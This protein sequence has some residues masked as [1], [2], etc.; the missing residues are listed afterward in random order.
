MAGL[1]HNINN[2][3][4]CKGFKY[5][6]YQSFNSGYLS[7]YAQEWDCRVI[8]L[9]KKLGNNCGICKNWGAEKMWECWY[10]F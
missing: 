5:I 2:Y 8:F 7:V 4:K 9:S 3:I 1:S 10:A 6:N